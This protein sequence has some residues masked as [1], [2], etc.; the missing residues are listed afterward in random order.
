MVG[1]TK[2]VSSIDEDS[3]ERLRVKATMAESS[4][5]STSDSNN[6]RWRAKPDSRLSLH[7]PVTNTSPD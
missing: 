3:S 1:L 6:F 2:Q 7:K 4:E 5:E